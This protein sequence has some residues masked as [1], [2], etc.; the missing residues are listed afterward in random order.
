MT[1]LVHPSGAA[2]AAGNA[3]A[4]ALAGLA[5]VLEL[6]SQAAVRIA[7]FLAVLAAFIALVALVGNVFAR[8]VLGYSVFGAY[9]VA[10]FAFL[11]TIWMG[12]SLAVKRSAVTVLTLVSHHGAPWWQR[13]VRTF[14]GVSL[15]ILLAYSCYRAT[16]F[17]LGQVGPA[18]VTTA[19]EVSWFY[20]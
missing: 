3:P 10:Q 16:Q 4:R 17:A 1:T 13:S 20:P 6:Y 7:R 5:E 12:V 9:E 19:L 14:S 2:G 8:E 18:G 11:W 15:G